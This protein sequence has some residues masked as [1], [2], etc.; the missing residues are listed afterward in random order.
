MQTRLGINAKLT[1]LLLLVGLIPIV[2]V[3]GASSNLGSKEL[4]ESV[5]KKLE[6]TRR[7]HKDGIERYFKERLADLHVLSTNPTMTDSL[8]AFEESFVREGGQV[9]GALWGK[10]E[11]RHGVWLSQYKDAYGYYDLF[12]ITPNGD[13][14]YT[15]ER[16][17]DFGANLVTGMLKE[18]GLGRLFERAVKGC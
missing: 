2:I 5:F 6:V 10:T 13:I 1:T 8:L 11:Q 17:S 14:V 3:G 18:S 7:L 16:E 15:A 9:G 12:L 4:F